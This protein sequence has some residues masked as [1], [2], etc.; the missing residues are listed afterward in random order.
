MQIINK[1]ART[2][3]NLIENLSVIDVYNPQENLIFWLDDNVSEEIYN[4]IADHDM[5]KIKKERRQ[6]VC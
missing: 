3:F 1:E 5:D 6:W 2:V 4:R